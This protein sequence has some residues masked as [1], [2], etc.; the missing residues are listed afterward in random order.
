M[1]QRLFY[2]SVAISVICGVSIFLLFG[3]FSPSVQ[4]AGALN[5]GGQNPDFG[6]GYAVLSVDESRDDR[7]IRESL[8]G[9]GFKG[10]ISES[11][12]EIPVDDFGSLKMVPLDSFRDEIEPFDPR[13]TGY[14]A[15]LRAF[16]VRDGH[17]F[18]FIPMDRIAVFSFE[19]IKKQL[20]VL[21]GDTQFGLAILGEKRNPLL[22]FMFLA[23]AC[24]GVLCLSRSR[25][26]FIF[27]V[28]V[29]LAFGFCGAF[30]FVLAA[31]MAG[32][33]E[34]LREPLG[35]LSAARYYARTSDYAGKG[36]GGIL[37]RLRPYRLNLLLA[38]LFLKIFAVV[39]V[40]SAFPL[41]PLAAGCAAFFFLYK[42]A[43]LAESRR[44]RENQHIPF[45]PVLMMPSRLRTFSLSPV[46][47]PFGAVSLL[48]LVLSL[49]FPGFRGAGEKD[50][51]IDPGYFVSL[52]DHRNNIAF[53]SSFSYRPVD[54][55]PAEGADAGALK[56]DDYLR[57]HLGED[58]LIGSSTDSSGKGVPDIPS[59]P[60]EK[61]MAFLVN[62]YKPGAAGE[63]DLLL[64]S[65][66]FNLKE[67]I[68]V[69]IIFAG[70]LLDLLK[71]GARGKKRKKLPVFGD[72]RIAA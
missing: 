71:G 62:Y 4:F 33:W 51:V 18:F 64:G 44:A 35:E 46:L 16:F 56:E 19:K 47:F 13:D 39:C 60:L 63:R 58:G 57:Y 9:A 48:A 21:L 34:L 6:S 54:Q 61:L 2:L 41:P 42:L 27:Q 70:C 66:H 53:Q 15:K 29:L 12:Q 14:A 32:I 30:A 72:R 24:A 37:K 8:A 43:F 67:W 23:A 40:I 22:N 7:Q 69:L 65:S 68:S 59:F 1:S 45:T 50:P 10:I 11:T 5:S 25:R 28:P 38:L 52:E 49:L 31:I 36:F 55:E 3:M 20:S 17:R 26:L